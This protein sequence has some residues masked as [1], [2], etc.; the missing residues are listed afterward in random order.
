M[1]NKQSDERP[2]NAQAIGSLNLSKVDDLPPP[3]QGKEFRKL[4]AKRIGDS[5]K[6]GGRLKLFFRSFHLMGLLPA[7]PFTFLM[8]VVWFLIYYHNVENPFTGMYGDGLMGYLTITSL[9]IWL[10]LSTLRSAGSVF[11]LLPVAFNTTTQLSLDLLEDG[12]ASRL[13]YLLSNTLQ[14]GSYGSFRQLEETTNLYH[15]TSK[16]KLDTINFVPVDSIHRKIEAV[17]YMNAI[18]NMIADNLSYQ[19]KRAN[20][21]D[22]P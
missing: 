14:C 8:L 12:T 7:L 6:P 19:Y 1:K 21:N 9:S 3:I 15:D 22:Q 13:Y 16:G 17:G 10:L 18:V 20:E 11:R 2:D 4:Y 5:R